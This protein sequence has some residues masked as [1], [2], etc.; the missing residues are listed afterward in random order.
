ML[1]VD[2][3]NQ[4]GVGNGSLLAMYIKSSNIIYN[5]VVGATQTALNTT[6]LSIGHISPAAK[7][8]A[9]STSEQ[10]RVGYDA[11][12]YFSTTVGATG[13]VVLD[14]VGAGA[15][16][17]FSDSVK[18]NAAFGCNSATPQT[19]YAS[20]GALA[21]YSTGAFGLDSDAHMQA[22]YNLVAAMRAALVANGIM[23]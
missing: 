10:L 15:S 20:G 1:W 13:A 5:Q 22:M 14:A 16:F 18:I 23:S 2:N 19:A 11:S 17:T 12:N 9:I 21:A 3:A 7:L 6:G 8:H 4:Q